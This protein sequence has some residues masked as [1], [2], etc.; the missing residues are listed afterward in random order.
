MRRIVLAAAAV[1]LLSGAAMADDSDGIDCNNA[2]TQMAMNIC[3][4]RDYQAADRRLNDTYRALMAML[5]GD[6]RQ[7][8]IAAERAWIG[9]RD[10]HCRSETAE[11]EGGSIHPMMYSSCLTDM[12]K[13][14]LKEL[15]ASLA[16]QRHGEK[17][18]D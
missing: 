16:C 12:T 7:K 9:F 5:D 18:Y 8:L 11:S 1:V 17:C 14:R 2:M 4:D 3:A 13:A 15:Q 10:A 6:Q